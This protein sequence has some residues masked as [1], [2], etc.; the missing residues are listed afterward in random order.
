MSFK[1]ISM[2]NNRLSFLTTDKTALEEK[3][4]ADRRSLHSNEGKLLVIKAEIQE[5]E[6]FQKR[7]P[8]Q[9][10]MISIDG[11]VSFS[12]EYWQCFVRNE[13]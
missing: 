12:E 8:N 11:S 1:I 3:I 6:Q 7:L 4:T 13:G 2:L 10:P 5:L 9:S